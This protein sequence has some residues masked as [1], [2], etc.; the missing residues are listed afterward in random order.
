MSL[1]VSK[2][3]LRRGQR[4]QNRPGW[5]GAKGTLR[6]RPY[7]QGHRAEFVVSV[8]RIREDAPVYLCI[9]SFSGAFEYLLHARPRHWE[10]PRIN[11]GRGLARD[12][13]LRLHGRGVKKSVPVLTK[14]HVLSESREGGHLR[15]VPGAQALLFCSMYG[16]AEADLAGCA[17]QGQPPSRRQ[18]GPI[19]PAPPPPPPHRDL[20]PRQEKPTAL[21]RPSWG[22]MVCS[23]LCYFQIIRVA[24]AGMLHK[25]RKIVTS[26]KLKNLCPHLHL[27]SLSVILQ[28]KIIESPEYICPYV[29]GLKKF[30]NV[31]SGWITENIG[32]NWK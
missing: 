23:G 11:L 20:C 2:C 6:R 1:D 32:Q 4:G 16:P 24:P 22:W 28:V 18:L 27:F 26:C 31:S 8:Y 29:R 17:V 10:I 25:R 12:W 15:P 30:S 5:D 7:P 19:A 14:R 13:P 21:I 9:Y 3:S